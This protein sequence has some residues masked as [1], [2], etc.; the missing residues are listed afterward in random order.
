M[1]GAAWLEPPPWE[2]GWCT[3]QRVHFGV[4]GSGFTPLCEVQRLLAGSVTP[5][6]FQTLPGVSVVALGLVT[7]VPAR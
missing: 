4:A 6:C 2:V 1:S 5:F 3:G 7:Q